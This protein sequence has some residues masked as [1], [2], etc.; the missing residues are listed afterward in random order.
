MIF[1]ICDRVLAY[2]LYEGTIIDIDGDNVIIGTKSGTINCHVDELELVPER[3]PIFKVFKTVNNTV[4]VMIQ[5][6]SPSVAS[7]L[8]RFDIWNS[9]GNFKYDENKPKEKPEIWFECPIEFLDFIESAMGKECFKRM[10]VK[11]FYIEK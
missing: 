5:N 9:N 3:I 8:W 4:N 11:E 10:G 2:G 7:F 6:C 1:K